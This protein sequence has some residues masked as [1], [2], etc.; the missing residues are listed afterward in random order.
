MLGPNADLRKPSNAQTWIADI[1]PT[2]AD[3]SGKID[4]NYQFVNKVSKKLPNLKI[5]IDRRA[6][7]SRN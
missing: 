4:I 5:G 7:F 1:Y 6:F 3:I 2:M